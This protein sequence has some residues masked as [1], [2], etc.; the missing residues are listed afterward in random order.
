MDLGQD[1]I[2]F[3]LP[4]TP[5]YIQTRSR[6]LFRSLETVGILLALIIRLLRYVALSP[7]REDLDLNIFVVALQDSFSRGP[8]LPFNHNWLRPW[9]WAQDHEFPLWGLTQSLAILSLASH[10]LLLGPPRSTSHYLSSPYSGSLVSTPI[11]P[12]ITIITATLLCG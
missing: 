8:T 10:H 6:W 4:F 7:F 2:H 12:S 9:T 3:W 11:L 5:R 1:S